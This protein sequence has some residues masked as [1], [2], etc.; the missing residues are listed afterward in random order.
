MEKFFDANLLTIKHLVF[1]NQLKIFRFDKMAAKYKMASKTYV[2]VFLLPNLQ[3]S[4]QFK[5]LFCIQSVLIL[6]NFYRK[7]FFSKI[8]NGGFFQDDVIFQKKLTFFQESL[9]HPKLNFFQ[10]LKTSFCSAK[11]QYI[12]KKIAK[13]FFTKWRRYLRWRLGIISY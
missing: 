5:N 8:Q 13:N 4:S 2:F 7:N 3:F 6:S 1:Q 9:S 11:T 10:I 12:A